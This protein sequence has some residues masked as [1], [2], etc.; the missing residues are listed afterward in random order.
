MIMKQIRVIHCLGRL[1]T[2]GAE[3]LFMNVVRKIDRTKMRFDVLLF[4]EKKGF[5]D[6]EARKLG[7]GFYYTK[8]MTKVGIFSY[9][10]GMISFFKSQKIDVVHSHMDWQGGFIAYAAHRA[11]V[12]KI[13]VHSH[14][15]QLLFEQNIIYKYMIRLNQYLIKK[16]ATD[17]CA[18][19]QEAGESLFRRRQFQI[20]TNGIDLKRYITPDF[21]II[22]SLKSEFNIGESDIILGNVGSFSENKNQLFLIELL[23]KL[24]LHS[25]AYKLILVGDGE[26]REKLINCVKQKEMSEHVI[27]AGVRSEIPEF[28]HLFDVFLFPSKLEGLGIV[29]VE[30]QACK[31]KCFLSD[32]IPREVDLKLGNV[33][34]LPL[35][36]KEK[37]I[38]EIKKMYES[39]NI[40]IDD[41]EI[42]ASKFNINNTVRQLEE[43]Y[44]L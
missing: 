1:D 38:E 11:G 15:K 27:F 21:K 17:L 32:T 7:V 2:G 26:T 14:A 18:C 16:Y 24:L 8:S 40:N 10:K 25:S 36:N 28:M 35:D 12:K 22:E 33:K 6:D 4:D 19:S 37:W 5:Y 44:Q 3:T 41:S 43:M 42:E 9:I 13:V 23:E 30:A 31:C 29:A 20:I 34:Y 39:N